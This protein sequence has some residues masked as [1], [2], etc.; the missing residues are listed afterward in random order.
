MVEMWRGTLATSVSR[1]RNSVDD[2]AAIE[3]LSLED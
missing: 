1:L 2:Q 3:A